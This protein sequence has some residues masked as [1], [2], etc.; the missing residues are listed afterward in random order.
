VAHPTVKPLA[1]MRW[2]VRL[3]TPPDGLVVDTFGGSGTTGE[4]CLLEDVRCLLIE[5][6]ASY[7]PLIDA[8]LSV[9]T[10][11]DLGPENTEGVA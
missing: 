10:P 6:E 5:R 2:L 9:H 7:I 1:L 8:R 4:A 3:V 11:R